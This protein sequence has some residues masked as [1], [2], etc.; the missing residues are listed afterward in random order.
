MPRASKHLPGAG[1]SEAQLERWLWEAMRTS[2]CLLPTTPEE[3]EKA[4]G[5]TEV[6]DGRLPEKL[7]DPYRLLDQWSVLDAVPSSAETVIDQNVMM[8]LAQAARDGKPIPPDV[9][10]IMNCDREAAER[11]QR[12]PELGP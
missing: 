7:L 12:K 6:V 9:E 8:N 2:G 11:E 1:P 10:A 3:V 5:E 4:E